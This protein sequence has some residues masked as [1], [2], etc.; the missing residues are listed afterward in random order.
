MDIQT[1][2]LTYTYMGGT[3]FE[4][5]ALHDMNVTI[6]EGHF[7]SLL[8]HTGSGKSTF[9]Q[10]LNGLLKPT[11]GNVS[12]GDWTIQAHTK[13]KGLFELRKQV[14]MVFQFPEHQLFHETVL[15]DTAYGPENYGLS[16]A[17]AKEKAA[18]YLRMC[19]IR[20]DLFDRSPFDLSGGQMRRVAIAGVLAIEPQLLI[21]DEP[22]AGLDPEAH[23][24]MMQLFYDWFKAEE[25]RSIIL[26]TH[27]MED[28]ALY[29]DDIIVM[30]KGHVYMKGTPAE[31]FSKTD[32]LE[33]FD[34][35][36]PESVKLLSLLNAKDEEE[37]DTQAFTLDDT[38]SRLLTYLGKDVT[39]RV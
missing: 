27:H 22:A 35:S 29:S 12:I 16:K 20:D 38:V 10:H 1:N 13:Q 26:V 19:G 6:P 14:G 11:S 31:V 4:K 2:A 30:D 33:A 18:H 15:L 21:L 23:Q 28:A 24:M 8:G 39:S 34:L 5:K 37:I 9:V 7:T 36:V 25:K 32:E 17:D 3:P